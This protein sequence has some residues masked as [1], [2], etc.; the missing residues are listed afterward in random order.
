M[1]EKLI[2]HEGASDAK[3]TDL[4]EEFNLLKFTA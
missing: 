2:K 1:K 4:E 3:K